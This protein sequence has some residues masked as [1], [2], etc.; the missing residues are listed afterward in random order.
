MGQVFFSS[1]A[2]I[3]LGINK[4][5]KTG[6]YSVK[7]NLKRQID[8]E[9]AD[10]FD[11]YY[12]IQSFIEKKH[13]PFFHSRTQNGLLFNEMVLFTGQGP[14]EGE[15][16]NE[17]WR[18]RAGGR[19]L[20]QCNCNLQPDTC[21]FP[22][23]GLD[24]GVNTGTAARLILGCVA[25]RAFCCQALRVETHQQ[26]WQSILP[27]GSRWQC[28]LD[29]GFRE[30]DFSYSCAFRPTSVCRKPCVRAV[31]FV[32]DDNKQKYVHVNYFKCTD[33][34]INVAMQK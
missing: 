28:T 13:I 7:R 15:A 33:N 20:I 17:V 2:L 10:W 5:L 31:K 32:S 19:R 22:W 9:I 29:G 6:L 26:L 8:W 18:T 27:G 1:L 24:S 11:S 3:I 30:L 16:T 14:R 21:V 34:I 4:G 23:Q 12:K 25:Y